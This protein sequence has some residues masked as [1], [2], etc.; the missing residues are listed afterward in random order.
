MRLKLISC[1][2]LF[3]EMC[4]VVARSP[5]QIDVEF[6]PKGLHDLA[7]ARMRDRIQERIDATDVA[8][9]DA[10]LL[11][12]GLCGNGALGIAARRIPIVMP[13]VHDCIALLM[14]SRQRYQQYFDSHSGVYFRSPGWLERGE[15]LDQSK[16]ERNRFRTGVGLKLEELIARYGED[17]GRYVYEQLTAYQHTYRQLTY[18]QTGVEQDNSFEQRT[19]DEARTRGWQFESLQGSLTLFERLVNGNWSA[20]DF[21]TVPPGAVVQRRFDTDIIGAS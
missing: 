19:R 20:D 6:L 17:D 1:E 14:G 3:R 12:Y 21:L 15:D 5:H 2:V 7:G 10:I 4:A 8:R 16:L 13:R 18:I 9:Y 11:G